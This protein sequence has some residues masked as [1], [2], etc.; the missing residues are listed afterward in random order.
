[1]AKHHGKVPPST[2]YEN[3]RSRPKSWVCYTMRP[4]LRF[5]EYEKSF[6]KLKILTLLPFSYVS[7]LCN[8]TFHDV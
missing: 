3:L 1:M 2:A 7:L 8:E 6:C 4:Y 5:E